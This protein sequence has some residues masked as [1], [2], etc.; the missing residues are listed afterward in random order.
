MRQ[1]GR[2]TVA[3]DRRWWAWTVLLAAGLAVRLV[4]LEDR[5]LWLDEWVSLQVAAAPWLDIVRGEVFDNHT[6]PLYYLLLHGWF[7][8]VPPE[9]GTLR[10]LSVIIDVACLGLFTLVALRWF[11]SRPGWIA[12]AAYALSPFTVH[13]AQ[14]G[15]MYPLLLLLVVAT[16]ALALELDARRE[17]RW[18]AIGAAATATA[19]LYTHY[20]AAL[21][22]VVLHA[23]MAWRLRE[24]PVARRRWWAAMAAT[25][26]AYLPWMPVVVALLSSGG[27]LH[28]PFGLAVLPHAGLRMVVGWAVLPLSVDAKSHL[29]ATVLAHLPLLLTVTAAAAAVLVLGGRQ[30]VGSPAGRLTLVLALVPPLVAGVLT[31]QVRSLEARYLA[32][33]F[34]FLLLVAALAPWGRA[35]PRWWLPVQAL[36]LVTFLYGAAAQLM[37]PAAGS[38]PWAAAA[39]ELRAVAPPDAPVAVAPDFYAPLLEYHLG[40]GAHV[41]SVDE[42]KPD[43]AEGWLVEVAFLSD[44]GEQLRRQGWRVERYRLLPDG[45]GLRLSRLEGPPSSR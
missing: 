41:V 12:G 4:G 45:N 6:P 18:P 14:E 7:R 17:A 28:R 43:G 3:G 24:A 42:L 32:I 1:P 19:A 23:C 8:L 15:R 31:T 5:S 9:L 27:Q 11:G 2:A 21:F 26:L 37:A 34:P 36:A 35:R 25:G 39:A 16:F 20:Y 22:L 30:A 44:R 13:L 40:P 29:T 38:T 33:C 10:L